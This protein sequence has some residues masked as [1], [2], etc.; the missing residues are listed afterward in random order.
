VN[1]LPPA[2]RE[3]VEAIPTRLSL[4]PEQIDAAIE[5]ARAATLSLPA[6]RS[7]LRDRR[8]TMPPGK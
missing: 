1:D 8:T 6:L 7:Y 4:A 3:R 5:G 2:L